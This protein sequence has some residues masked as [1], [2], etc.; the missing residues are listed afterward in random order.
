MNAFV[1]SQGKTLPFVDEKQP[2]ALKPLDYYTQTKILGEKVR[3]SVFL[4]IRAM[5]VTFSV[6][7]QHPG[8]CSTT[9]ATT[10]ATLLPSIHPPAL[11]VPWLTC[12]C[13]LNLCVTSLQL[14]LVADRN[15]VHCHVLCH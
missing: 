11:S 8:T 15:G 2:Y 7:V 14:A 5:L 1:S 6:V 13:A 10:T 3:R 9:T 4:S 12:S